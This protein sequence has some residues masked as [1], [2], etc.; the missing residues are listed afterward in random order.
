M[1]TLRLTSCHFGF[2]LEFATA[3]GSI[4]AITPSNLAP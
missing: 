1:K 3:A 2:G 4:A